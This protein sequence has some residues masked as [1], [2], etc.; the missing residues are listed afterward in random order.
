MVVLREWHTGWCNVVLVPL[1]L[2]F[3]GSIPGQIK[4]FSASEHAPLACIGSD[5]VN[6]VLLSQ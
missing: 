6:T 1:V 5:D 4:K 3:L 2:E